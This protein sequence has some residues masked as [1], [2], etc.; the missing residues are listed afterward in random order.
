MNELERHEGTAAAGKPAAPTASKGP[1]STGNGT[2][3]DA[4]KGASD[5]AQETL[6]SVRKRAV[7]VYDDAADAARQSY[8]T[9]SRGAARLRRNA[10]ASPGQ[11]SRMV[12]RYVEENPIMVGVIGLAAGLILGSVLPGTRKE[13]EVFGRYADDVKDQ[14]LRYAR[15]LAEQGKHYVEEGLQAA[16]EGATDRA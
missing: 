3:Q 8:E 13:N 16:R 11:A 7:H 4:V 15:D 12:A 2:A 1:E 5:A 14:G 9:V 6:K 10:P